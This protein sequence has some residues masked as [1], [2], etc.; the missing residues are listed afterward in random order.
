MRLLQVLTL[1]ILA[2]TGLAHAS[3][4]ALPTP[5]SDHLKAQGP[6]YTKKIY[7]KSSSQLVIYYCIDTNLPGG[8]TEG[9]N[10]PANTSCSIAIFNKALGKWL[11]GDERDL[12][13]G[14]VKKFTSNRVTTETIEYDLSKDALCCP[15][16]KLEKMFRIRNG[17]FFDEKP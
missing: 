16:V 11:L 9:A 10:N 1:F 12:G 3:N 2:S 14:R 5:V 8:A 7:K 13:Q 15:S 4:N 6:L 17:K